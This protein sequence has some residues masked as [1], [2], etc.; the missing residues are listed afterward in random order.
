MH[1]SVFTDTD[2]LYP[3][4]THNGIKAVR[5]TLPRGGHAGAQILGDIPKAPFHFKFFWHQDAQNAGLTISLYKLLPVGVN[6][7]TDSEFMT[8]TDFERCKSFVTRKAPFDIY[9]ALCPIDDEPI[10]DRFALYLCIDACTDAV[11]GTYS[12]ELCLYENSL[13]TKI[14][15]T[16][17]VSSILV[18]PL[19]S[20]LLGMLNFFDYDGLAMQHHVVKN[21]PEYWELFSHYVKAQIELRCTHILLPPGEPLFENGKLIDFDFSMAQKAGQIARKE[22][23]RWLCGGH[24]AHWHAWDEKEYYPNWDQSL[25]ITTTEGYLQLRLYFTKWNE[26]I[27]KNNWQSCMTQA[28]ADEPQTHND[29]TY[30]I[31]AGIFRKFMPGIPII[32]AVETTNLG[33]GIDIW[34]PKQDTYEKWRDEYEKLQ[35]AG[36]TMWF[37]TCAFPAGPIMNRSMDLPLTASRA[38]F[39]MGARYQLSGFLHWGFNYY[40]GSDIWH[41]AC[42]PH[43]GALLP[44]G[45]AHIVYPGKNGPLRSM[46][47]EAQ[48]AGAEDYELLVQASGAAPEKTRR[49]IEKVC[50][51]FQNYTREGAVLTESK[52]N[53]IKLLESEV[54]F[55][56]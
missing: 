40:I 31:L 44:A 28:L 9:D 25:G 42:C 4:S 16:C 55:H 35:A 22:G 36:E 30:R 14:P 11:P 56:A 47:F 27:S 12:G 53:L 38:V 50:T 41:S 7:N 18:P 32:D 46:R 45:D 17:Q 33:G 48:R 24:I 1:Y 19:S 8:T 10:Q 2:W 21:S 6:E 3:D 13:E 37:Y 15:L 51:S 43:K 52:N 49:L 34:V 39:W 26:I 20:S 5:L 29:S 23:A 54:S